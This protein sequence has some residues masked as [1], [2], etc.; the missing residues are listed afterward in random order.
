V[1]PLKHLLQLVSR[2][3]VEFARLL[4]WLECWQFKN[5]SQLRNGNA[6]VTGDSVEWNVVPIGFFGFIAG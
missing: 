3:Q 2:P 6:Q 1:Q 4:C 5:P